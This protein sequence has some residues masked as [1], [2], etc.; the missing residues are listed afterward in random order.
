MA[1]GVKTSAL[2]WTAFIFCSFSSPTCFLFAFLFFLPRQRAWRANT[3]SSG[4]QTL[5]HYADSNEQLLPDFFSLS[6]GRWNAQP[7][8]WHFG[9]NVP[10]T[11]VNIL[12]ECRHPS[13]LLRAQCVKRINR[14]LKLTDNA[15]PAQWVAQIGFFCASSYGSPGSCSFSK[16]RK[17]QN[18]RRNTHTSFNV[19]GLIRS[20]EVTLYITI[21]LVIGFYFSKLQSNLWRMAQ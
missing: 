6:T 1:P 11:I 15:D 9:S 5:E 19:D 10:E 21:S 17:E 2:Y 18:I 7:S 3:S 8:L 20:H 13:A 14:C 16:K 4:R 12:L